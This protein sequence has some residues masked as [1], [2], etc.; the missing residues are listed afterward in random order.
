MR[1]GGTVGENPPIGTGSSTAYNLVI[2]NDFF[3]DVIRH[4]QKSQNPRHH[5]HNKV[6]FQTY[7]EGNAGN[8]LSRVLEYMRMKQI[9]FKTPYFCC[10]EAGAPNI[11][12][13]PKIGG[14]VVVLLSAAAVWAKG[15]DPKGDDC[16]VVVVVVVAAGVCPNENVN[17][18]DPETGVLFA[19]VVVAAGVLVEF[20]GNENLGV[21]VVLLPVLAL[22][23]LVVEVDVEAPFPN[24]TLLGASV[25]LL[26]NTLLPNMF[27]VWLC[28]MPNGEGLVPVLFEKAVVVFVLPPP[29]TDF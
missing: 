16:G 27:G 4:I 23:A 17:P 26:P 6:I 18:P 29:N 8:D 10:C 3:R 12:S 11:P 19:A 5:R 15:D 1:D 14:L 9:V 2:D 20:T 25:E 22:G 7:H 21:V 28:C 24:T 13:P